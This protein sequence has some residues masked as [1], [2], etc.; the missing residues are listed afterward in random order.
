MYLK[1]Q[2][3]VS[4]PLD[5]SVE[6]VISN[7]RFCSQFRSCDKNFGSRSERTFQYA[8][9]L[10]RSVVRLIEIQRYIE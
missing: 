1:I 3:L 6:R 8:H 7:V 4:F 9:T 10:C 2:I 5:I